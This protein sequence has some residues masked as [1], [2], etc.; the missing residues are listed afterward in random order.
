MNKQTRLRRIV[1]SRFLATIA[2][3]AVAEYLVFLLINKGAIP[4]ARFLIAPHMEKI[5]DLSLGVV[6]V[7][8][9]CLIVILLMRILAFFFPTMHGA[10]E[11]LLNS[12]IESVSSTKIE[13]DETGTG[14]IVLILFVLLA[15]LIL[16]VIP[17]VLG[18]IV[19]TGIVSAKFRELDR[20]Y[21]EERRKAEKDRYL[22]ISDIV[23]DLKT[24]MTTVLGYS[25]AL[26]EGMVK[27]DEQ[28]EYLE[29]IS[30]K[31]ER[32]NEIVNLLFD[33]VKLDSEGFKLVKTK[34]DLN[35]LVREVVALQ[36]SDIEDAG[37][38]I[39]CGIPDQVISIEADKMQFKRVI[40]NLL[41]NA[42]KHNAKGT[43]IGVFV[44]DEY[45][46]IRIYIADSGD[47]I[48][49][50]VAESLFDPFVMGDKSRRSGGGTGLGLSISRKICDMH[51]FKIKLVQKPD[52]VR[53]KLD[54]KYNKVFV[55]I[56]D[57]PV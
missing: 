15:I 25:K 3:V 30:G 2:I 17:Y 57:K 48:E 42:V 40:T 20:E 53:Y 33:Y 37:D 9:A 24:P 22:M 21:E 32:M 14:T 4:L 52:M 55:I 47:M 16:A 6:I 34:T 23:H 50:S 10:S 26:N 7:G 35:E 38:S 29:A 28:Q 31:T 19:Y 43:D 41:V 1:I 8:I 12:L 51:E 27:P 46:D 5:E 11:A 49:P 39:D 56:I 36:Y 44:R 45:E 54:E 13:P 18:A